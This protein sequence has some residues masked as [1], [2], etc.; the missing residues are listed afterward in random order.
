M[1]DLVSSQGILVVGL[2]Q[3]LEFRGGQRPMLEK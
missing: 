3:A 1:P 2:V